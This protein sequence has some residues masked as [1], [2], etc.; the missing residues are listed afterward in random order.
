M[1][2]D[3]D[4]S[5]KWLI[6]HRG[7]SILRLGGVRRIRSWRPRPPEIVQPRQLPDGLLEVQLQDQDDMDLYLVEIA[8]YPEERLLEQVVRGTMLVYL[9]RHVLPEALTIILRPRGNFQIGGYRELVSRQG[10]TRVQ[11]NWRVVELWTLPAAELLAANDVGLIPWVPLTHFEGPPEPILQQCRELIDRH[12]P[13][14]ERANLLAVS[15]V[16]TRLRYNDRELL[17]IFGGSRIMI[18]SPLIQEL[19][20]EKI[21]KP[22]LRLL[23]ARFGSVPQD[24]A[25]ALQNIQDEQRLDDLVVWAGLCPDLPAFRARL[26]A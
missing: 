3:Y 5:S 7:D 22:I 17:S 23:S 6:Q 1:H 19:F 10:W 4:R 13:A 15:Q 26:S 12:A 8:T 21:H 18:E 25:M 9:D 14:E 24:I 2:D 16:L 20:A 11:T